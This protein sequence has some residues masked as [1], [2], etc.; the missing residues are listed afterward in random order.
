MALSR[1]QNE[2]WRSLVLVT[3]VLDDA[4]DRQAQRDGGLPHAYY[5]VLVF[6]Y[7]SPGK[8]L[9]MSELAAQQ[10]YSTSRMTHAVSS[11]EASGWVRRTRAEHDGRVRYV[12]LTDEGIAL[13][14]AVSPRQVEEVREKAFSR[15]DSVQVSQLAAISLALVEGLDGPRAGDAVSD[16]D[17]DG[18]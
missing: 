4:L 2:A 14:R 3:H 1:E 12:E 7:E 17:G 5:K 9:T 10:R 13:V 18:D 6:L 15:L 8:R 11:M 16:A